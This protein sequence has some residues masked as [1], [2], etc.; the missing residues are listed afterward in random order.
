MPSE[1]P[2]TEVPEEFLTIL[3]TIDEIIQ[4]NLSD[5]KGTGLA[6]CVEKSALAQNLSA[7]LGYDGYMMM[8]SHCEF[9]QSDN[10]DGHAYNVLVTHRGASIYDSTN[11]IV[12]HDE[13]G[14]YVRTYPALYRLTLESG[15][16]FNAVKPSRSPIVTKFS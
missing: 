8:S 1:Q 10:S 12:V 14:A 6:V 4:S 13:D 9:P 7:F 2:N 11:P 3:P 15:E 16:R 5:F